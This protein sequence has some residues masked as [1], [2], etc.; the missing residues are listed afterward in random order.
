MKIRGW[1]LIIS[2]I[3]IF[4]L[5]LL[6]LGNLQVINNR[7]TNKIAFVVALLCI[8]I[9]LF[10]IMKT[11]HDFFSKTKAEETIQIKEKKE[12]QLVN[13]V[14]GLL[15]IG[16]VFYFSKSWP[17]FFT[18]PK[19]ISGL[20]LILTKRNNLFSFLFLLII[21][22][23]VNIFIIT[24]DNFLILGSAIYMFLSV[25]LRMFK[26]KKHVIIA[27]VAVLLLGSS[28]F[29]E[30][31]TTFV[32]KDNLTIT[33][34]IDNKISI[35]LVSDT[36]Q[37]ATSFYFNRG[38]SPQAKG[39][40]AGVYVYQVVNR[41]GGVF[42]SLDQWP[43]LKV[44][45]DGG[46]I[47]RGIVIS[48]LD[49]KNVALHGGF[50][51]EGWFPL[52]PGDYIVQL[53]KIEKTEGVIVAESNFS[54]VPYDKQMLSKVTAYLA[55]KGDPNKYYDSYTKKGNDSVSVTAWVQF[56]KGEA[57]SGVVKF[58]MT[59]SD[60]N[61]EKTSWVGVTESTFRT[62]LDGQPVSLRNLSGNPFPGIY[63]YEII[64]DGNVVFDLKYDC[65]K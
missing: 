36:G 43:I 38:I 51:L 13:I 41:G 2:A 64:I 31:K 28:L 57:I 37:V 23:L 45:A 34:R 5:N 9:F 33:R 1:Y 14:L 42:I 46:I 60:G 54:I 6:T 19:L 55:V 52:S 50:N 11:L 12:W 21:G 65:S 39:V 16:F 53:I 17:P 4:L 3:I 27:L 15:I 40:E 10:G 29:W 47:Q 22:L 62:G 20:I 59:D 58:F 8:I 7:I 25:I 49:L 26:V 24:P 61:I 63:H 18:L 30:Y 48:W 32:S 44:K 35:E 56:P